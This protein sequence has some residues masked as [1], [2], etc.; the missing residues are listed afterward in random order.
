MRSCQGLWS[1]HTWCY[2]GKKVLFC[3]SRRAF[4]LCFKK[5]AC[6]L[7]SRWRLQRGNLGWWRRHTSWA[8]CVTVR[9]RWSFST[10]PTSCSSTPARTWTRCCSSTPSTTSRTR[11]G[12]TQTSWRWA[13]MR[14]WW[15][16]KLRQ[17]RLVQPFPPLFPAS[18]QAQLPF[19][20]MFICPQVSPELLPRLLLH[21]LSLYLKMR[22][23][24]GLVVGTPWICSLL[25]IRHLV[26]LLIS[27]FLS[28][29]CPPQC[30]ATRNGTCGYGDSSPT[31]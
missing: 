31:F 17:S 5:P 27:S 15:T 21:P 10:A 23:E 18:T 24:R 30:Q 28:R 1:R 19:P 11:A 26:K 2:K 29:P 14:A 8:C 16:P 7:S 20:K 12:R 22:S 4:S 3:F 6:L 25:G 13:R 9:L